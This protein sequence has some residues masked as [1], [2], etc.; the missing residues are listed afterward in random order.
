MRIN[1]GHKLIAVMGLLVLGACGLTVCADRVLE[2]Q[3]ARMAAMGEVYERALSAQDLALAVERTVNAA[4][5]V[6]SAADVEGAKAQFAPLK[7]A[8]QQVEASKR[9]FLARIDGR[10]DPAWLTRIGLLLNEF[11]A[12]QT[13]TAE[14]GTTISPKAALIQA[15]DE[16]TIANRSRMIAQITRVGHDT[17]A[18]LATERVEARQALAR[19]RSLL[20]GGAMTVIVSTFLLALWLIR[21]HIRAPL[22]DLTTA[23]Q[24][25]AALDFAHAVPQ[26]GRRDEIGT[27]GDA[28]AILRTALIEKVEGDRLLR[29]SAEIQA[30]RGRHLDDAARAFEGVAGQVTVELAEV[31]AAFKEAAEAVACAVQVTRTQSALLVTEAAKTTDEIRIAAV[32]ASDVSAASET[33]DRQARIRGDLAEETRVEVGRTLAAAERL[34]HAGRAI[35]EV[36][37]TIAAVAAQTNLLALNATIEAARAGEAG[38]GFVVVAGEVKE[39]AGQTSAATTSIRGQIDAI[40]AATEATLTAVAA[41]GTRIAR[42]RDAEASASEAAETQ[43]TAA[44]RISNGVADAEAGAASVRHGIAH[45]DAA[46]G[47]SE[48]AA[49]SVLAAADRVAAVS[50]NLDAHIGAFLSR[51]R[52]A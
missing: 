15:T 52:A 1:L 41:I 34:A 14:L 3:Q 31:A 42:M 29:M 46:A 37:D 24:R 47:S 19:T 13:D 2:G 9:D 5:V 51:V 11:S 36:V 40:R 27:M 20:L 44:A 12:Y 43:K 39:L 30:E 18:A 7:Q 49:A 35:G 45:V 8:L 32:A 25:L 21:H 16:A 50:R 28:V 4:G 17:L 48:V 26:T 6:Y 33:I 38:R 10:V 22:R 23:L